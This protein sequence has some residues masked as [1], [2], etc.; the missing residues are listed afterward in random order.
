MKVEKPKLYLNVNIWLCLAF[1]LISITLDAGDQLT[2]L[3][4]SILNSV[5]AVGGHVSQLL[6]FY[7]NK[8]SD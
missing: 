6:E 1:Y 8:E 2:F 7:N 5:F 4:L 3:G